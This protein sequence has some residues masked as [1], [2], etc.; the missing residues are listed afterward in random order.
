[1][2]VKIIYCVEIKV[3][4]HFDADHR[5]RSALGMY[6]ISWI[7]ARVICPNGGV[8]EREHGMLTKLLL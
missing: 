8:G 5:F 3:V 1:M 6:H 2:L 7:F 4:S